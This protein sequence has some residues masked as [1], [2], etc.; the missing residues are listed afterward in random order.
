M[1]SGME[2]SS[3]K[4]EVKMGNVRTLLEDPIPLDQ[5]PEYPK[6]ELLVAEGGE[7]TFDIS[8]FCKFGDGRPVIPFERKAEQGE[9]LRDKNMRY[10]AD[11]H[12]NLMYRGDVLMKAANNERMQLLEMQRCASDILYYINVFC[13]T[14]VPG[15][16]P[17]PFILY[18]F[19]EDIA[20]WMLW[21]IKYELGG[22]VEKSR[23]MGL[24]WLTIAVLSYLILFYPSNV[25]YLFS[26][27]E[28]EVDNKTEDSLLGKLRVLLMRLP[29]W[30]RGGWKKGGKDEY[31]DTI[32]KLLEIKIPKTESRINGKLTGGQS[33][34][35]GRAV[36]SFY[37]EF[38]FI[39]NAG[40]VLASSA[41]LAPCEIYVST[42]CGM[43]N[44][45][46]RITHEPGVLKKS[47]HWTEHPLKNPKWAILER[48]KPKYTEERWNQEHEIDYTG[49]TSGRI[50]P[51]FITRVNSSELDIPQWGHLQEDWY[52]AFD[53]DYDVLV[54]MDFGISDPNAIVY[55]QEKPT[56][57]EFAHLNPYQSTLIIFDEDLN[58]DQTDDE[59]ALMLRR[60][61]EDYGYRYKTYVGDLRSANRR[62][63]DGK[64]MSLNLL[65]HGINLIGKYNTEDAPIKLVRKRLAYPGAIA[66]YK[67]GVPMII[68]AVQNWSFP[69]DKN[70]GLPKPGAKPN[71]DRYS[72]HNK[73]LAYLVDHIDAGN[74][75]EKR[76]RGRVVNWDYDPLNNFSL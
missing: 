43:G 1:E 3:K 67:F 14:F 61:T 28:G 57:P 59:L 56:P 64:T 60:K 62:N 30:I 8:D 50:Y 6:Y 70:S 19:Q 40:A 39:E 22:A 29:E 52:Y 45:F 58:R 23:E 15:K 17:I 12:E 76:K 63:S 75:T 66:F 47:P 69:T 18:D 27:T 5:I 11:I 24:S 55:A 9:F 2:S 16:E 21:L 54:G 4:H 35:S 7:T 34:R 10:K 31:G 48:S 68:E 53:P 20:T 46:A 49:S 42:V 65:K 74:K 51:R 32:D 71:H 13:W 25:G 72:H 36:V 26:M 41:T 44:E 38:A 73:A 37:D 33:G